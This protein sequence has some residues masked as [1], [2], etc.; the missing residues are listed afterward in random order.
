MARPKP[1]IARVQI[2]LKVK[3]AFLKM[4]DASRGSTS[5]ADFLEG[6]A[7]M[8]AYRGL[9]LDGEKLRGRG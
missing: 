6:L 5:R 2:S 1:D 9:K 3:P 8:A 4:I 7:L